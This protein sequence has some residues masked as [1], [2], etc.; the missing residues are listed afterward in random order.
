[1]ANTNGVKIARETER[2]LKIQIAR[3]R[4]KFDPKKKEMLHD[5]DA[6]RLTKIL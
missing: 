1:V 2:N 5:V 3:K 6:R 4:E